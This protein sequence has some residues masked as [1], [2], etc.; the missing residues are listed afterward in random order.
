MY[1]AVPINGQTWLICGGRDFADQSMFD[2]AMG[3]LLGRYG[4]PSKIVHGSATGADTM[5]DEFAKRLS[6][7]VVAMPADWGAFGL[8]AGP[9]RN[10]RMLEDH[11]PAMVI[12]FPG[13]AGTKDM[14][15]QARKARK[16][17]AS[18]DVVE[19]KP[20]P[21]HADERHQP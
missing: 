19:I 13:G 1:A 6:V 21:A 5:A 3:E 20:N 12:A 18:L 14:V 9:I 11:K 10:Y 8:R 16:N 2:S 7:E 4:C 17:G 15:R